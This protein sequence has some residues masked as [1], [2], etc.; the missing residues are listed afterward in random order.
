V[1]HGAFV[2]SAAVVE[3][4]GQGNRSLGAKE[5]TATSNGKS[6]A[7]SSFVSNYLTFPVG[8]TTQC[9]S[10]RQGAR[11]VPGSSERAFAIATCRA[12]LGMVRRMLFQQHRTSYRIGDR[13]ADLI[14][15]EH[16]GGLEL[17]FYVDALRDDLLATK[18]SSCQARSAGIGISDGS[19]IRTGYF[20]DEHSLARRLQADATPGHF[21]ASLIDQN[22]T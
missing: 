19:H 1:C 6:T 13:V 22:I 10:S 3:G 8:I 15:H 12:C 14:N 5:S 17:G 16:H 4:L 7:S 20:S 2:A 21:D 11:G 18:E 9:L